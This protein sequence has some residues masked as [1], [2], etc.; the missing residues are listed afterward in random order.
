MAH[1]RPT[2]LDVNL[3]AL[4]EN[5]A[6]ARQE[7]GGAELLAVVKA[8][9]YGHGA[10]AVARALERAGVQW[11][12]V[13]LVEEALEL[14]HAGLHAPIL[15]LGGA[16]EGAWDVMVKERL[17]PVLFRNDHF[18]Q[19]AKAARKAGTK[20]ACHLKVDTGMGR[21]GV[22]PEGVKALLDASATAFSAVELEGVVTHFANADLA[23]ATQT[24]AQIRRFQSAVETLEGAGLA[25]RFR[26]LANSAA[27]LTHPEASTALKLNMVR[28]GL[29]LYGA[30]PLPGGVAEA[31]P[32]R[33]VAT[34]KTAVTH[35]KEVAVGAAISYGGTWIAKR[36]SR[37]ATLPVGYADG[38]SRRFSNRAEVL[39]RGRRAP[40]VGRVCMDMCMIDVTDVANAAILD[41]VVLLGTQG[42][43][44]IAADELAGHMKSIS[45]EV[46][47]GIG[48]R[49][50]RVYSPGKVQK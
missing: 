29:M 28:P 14:R 2:V 13:A 27:V 49:V 31:R 24:R 4:A 1:F 46:F 22:V 38:Y 3:D 43:A 50:P 41:E 35:L 48:A 21:I 5:A 23:D 47:C 9:A 33:Q 30:S 15:V 45:Y 25:P 44:T 17:R 32:L 11:F 20:A 19:F 39:I 40:I 36:L 6:L 42:S 26:H 12:G 18:E 37:I 16:Y 34:W 8:N 7:A 10:V